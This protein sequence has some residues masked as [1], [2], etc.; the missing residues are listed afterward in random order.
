M[1]LESEFLWRHSREAAGADPERVWLEEVEGRLQE[2][3]E[4]SNFFLWRFDESK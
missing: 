3:P 1:E 4:K 2:R